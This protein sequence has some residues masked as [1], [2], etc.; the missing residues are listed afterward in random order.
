VETLNAL[1]SVIG[2]L[3][4]LLGDLVRRRVEWKR[5]E[6]MR[7]VDAAVPL[8]HSS[9]GFAENSSTHENRVCRAR[10]QPRPRAERYEAA[11]RFFTTPGSDALR[12]PA[13]ALIRAYGAL[14]DA[15]DD[16]LCPR[17]GK[18]ISR[19]RDGLRRA[20]EASCSV[21]VSSGFKRELPAV[22]RPTTCPRGPRRPF[23]G[24]ER[25]PSLPSEP[26]VSRS[27]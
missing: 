25:L 17:R 8:E 12:D 19:L 1:G 16:K 3:L 27:P 15:Y 9:T 22:H 20:Y 26:A 13:V 6:L 21:A 11:T 23:A 7:L 18:I 14:R 2:D 5:G 10:A 4:V 24:R